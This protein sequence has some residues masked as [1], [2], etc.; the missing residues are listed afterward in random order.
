MSIVINNLTKAFTP[1]TG[2]FD[3]NLQVAEG[4]SFGYLG[5]NGSGKTT[6]I[7]QLMGFMHPDSGNASINDLN[8]WSDRDKVKEQVGYLAGEIKF[9][10]GMSGRELLNL[11]GDMR[12][13]KDKSRRYNLI[14][15]F[16]IDINQKIKKM[17]KGTKQKMGIIMAFMHN[18][19]IL[20]L[21]EPSSGLDP[22]MQREFINLIYEEKKQ[23]KTIFMS[24]H[25][26][27][28]VQKTC[29]RIGIIKRGKLITIDSARELESA[30]GK[31]FK[32]VVASNM[33]IEKLRKNGA[34]LVSLSGL[35]AQVRVRGNYKQFF[36]LLSKCEIIDIETPQESL[37]E[38]FLQF[39]DKEVEHE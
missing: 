21:D 4:E 6:T 15:R 1:N 20:I 3:I 32:V 24:S 26:F 18:P 34:E 17:S 36:S 14:E 33:E 29:D 35:E 27:N 22:L 37:E 39:Y 19:R 38:R 25:M 5:P 16:D 7:R 8:C 10:E 30:S 11:I 9:I 28:E 13:L 31:L 2:I 12:N 23:G